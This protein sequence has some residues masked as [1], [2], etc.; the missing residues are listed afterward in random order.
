MGMFQMDI[1][2]G[3]P[4]GERVETVS[5]LVD[6]GATYTMLPS[7]LLRELGVESIESKTFIVADDRRLHDRR[8]QRGFDVA[9]VRIDGR[10]IPSPVVFGDDNSMPLLGAV[11][12]EIFALG[13]D[14]VHSRLIEIP[15]LA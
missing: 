11:T 8:L 5:A 10:E 1:E 7:S 2:V 12:S 14:H 9:N 13:I 15:S 4:L 6:S 3:D